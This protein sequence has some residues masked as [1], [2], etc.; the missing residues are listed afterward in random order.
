MKNIWIFCLAFHLL[1]VGSSF[2]NSDSSESLKVTKP[3]GKEN[4]VYKPEG[5]SFDVG[6]Q[7]T[8]MSF[9]SPPT[10][11]GSTG[12]AL[13]RI[14]YQKQ[15]SFFGQVRTVYNN[16]NLSSSTNEASESESYTEAVAG[17]CF[18]LSKMESPY[19]WTFTPYAGIGMEFLTEHRTSYTTDSELFVPS[20]K[21]RYQLYYAVAGL[22]IHCTVKKWSFGVQGDVIPSFQ[23]YLTIGGLSESAWKLKQRVGFDVRLPAAYQMVKNYWVELAPYYRLLGIGNS[24]VLG[25]PSRNL[26]QWGAFV[27]FRFFI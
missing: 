18:R 3:K 23:E 6:G 16:G 2:A 14:T 20:I 21:M 15:N 27:T 1:F 10:F 17:Y 7:Y 25:L 24:G 13:A 22:D 5:W 19:L 11:S 26:H 12:G 8:W 4:V 9:T